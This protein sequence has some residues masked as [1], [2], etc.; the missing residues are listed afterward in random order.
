MFPRAAGPASGDA[1]AVV[2]IRPG[3]SGIPTPWRGP[4][5]SALVLGGAGALLVAAGTV[6]TVT[7]RFS[8]SALVLVTAGAV[9]ALAGL[10]L[11]TA[12]AVRG[13]PGGS[14]A[15]LSGAAFAVL[16]LAG[17]LVWVAAFVMTTFTGSPVDPGPVP[18]PETTPAC[19]VGAC[20]EP[21]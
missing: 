19:V 2:R 8:V 16:G 13:C 14:G 5:A 1:G 7:S 10:V 15:A 18:I 12:E 17:G 6:V 11:G 20:P 9:C 21:P 3:V 4:G